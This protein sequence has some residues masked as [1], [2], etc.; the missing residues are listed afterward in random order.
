[1]ECPWDIR[2]AHLIWKCVLPKMSCCCNQDMSRVQSSFVHLSKMFLLIVHVGLQSAVRGGAVF[3]A[4]AN[5]GRTGALASRAGAQP[6]LVSMRVCGG[7]CGT[8]PWGAHHTERRQGPH[9]GHLPRDR[10]RHVQLGER[11]LEPRLHTRHP[12]PAKWLLPSQLC[13]GKI[14]A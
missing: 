5:A 1:M 7:A 12:L 10:R 6:N 14:V 2:W 11:R 8:W 3:P 13:S 4:A 9:R